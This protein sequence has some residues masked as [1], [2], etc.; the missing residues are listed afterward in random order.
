M[1]EEREKAECGGQEGGQGD[2]IRMV[3]QPRASESGGSGGSGLHD[4]SDHWS[5]IALHSSG[6]NRIPI[7]PK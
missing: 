4:K 2:I 6:H 7:N 5:N 3:S 1:Q